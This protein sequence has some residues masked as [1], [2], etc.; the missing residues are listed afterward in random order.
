MSVHLSQSPRLMQIDPFL[1]QFHPANPR[2]HQ[3]TEFLR[4]KHNIEKVGMVQFPT[5]R[6]LH[7]EFVE[8]LD[9]GGRVLVARENHEQQ[10]WVVNLGKVH[11]S[12][13]LMM[14]QAA[15]A[16]RTFGLLDEC[17]G[18]ANLHRQGES[19]RSLADKFSA[20]PS[21]IGRMVAIGYFPDDLLAL[22]RD[23][24]AQSE[25]H[26]QRWTYSLLRELLPL[27]Q[28]RGGKAPQHE[29]TLDD[30]YDYREVRLAIELV[31]RGEIA[32]SVH[33][34]HDYVT[35]RRLTLFETRFDQTL[36]TQVAIEL[37]KAKQAIHEGHAKELERVKELAKRESVEQY[38]ERL[39]RLQKKHEELNRDYHAAVSKVAKESAVVEQLQR[40]LQRQTK[41]T[42]QERRDL[43]EKKRNIEE[44]AQITEQHREQA[45]QRWRE[46][47]LERLQTKER[48]E[49]RQRKME[50][51]AHYSSRERELELKTAT[52]VHQVV[53]DCT[54]LL[55]EAQLSVLN[56]IS[57]DVLKGVIWLQRPEVMALIAQLHTV[58]ETL[59]QAEER[60]L[61]GDV[62]FEPERRSSDGSQAHH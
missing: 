45:N 39:Q 8:C 44:E 57:P 2:K 35:Q 53:A 29:Q 16:V 43:E 22:I 58:R 25:E 37:E 62:V 18:L 27:R 26:A 1:I 59:E 10:I 56:L 4:L 42:E 61:H 51:E 46:E 34:I 15:N 24:S 36:H 21:T 48:G 31:I 50:L 11:D 47:E 40:D 19:T 5:V 41:A 52:S 49:Q 60:L 3:G 30:C 17:R 54:R 6:D 7:A 28:E 32:G 12:D 9:G 13:A 23:D 55:S 38:E 14:L 33:D 20:D